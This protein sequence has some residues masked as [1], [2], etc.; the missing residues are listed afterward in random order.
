MPSVVSI[1]PNIS[2]AAFATT[3][4]T[5]SPALAAA[6]SSESAESMPEATCAWS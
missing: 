2:T 6:A 4:S 3:S 1:P 5:P